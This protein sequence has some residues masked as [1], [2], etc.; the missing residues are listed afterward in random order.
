MLSILIPAYNY[1]IFPLVMQL[2]RQCI[3]AGIDFEIITLDDSSHSKLNSENKK[4]NNL[5]HCSFAEL[6]HNIGRS[7]IRNL[8]AQKAKYNWLLF[9]D[10]D[11]MP[12]NENFIKNYIKIMADEEKVISGGIR[13]QAT[14]PDNDKLL[15]WIYGNKREAL[16]VEERRQLPYT[17]LLTLN[18]LIA[19]SVFHKVRFNENIPNLRHEDTLFSHNLEEASIKAEHIKNRVIH[20]GLES[21]EIFLHK[22]EES[23]IGLKFLID[24]KL[25]TAEYTRIGKVYI[26]LQNMGVAG[27]VAFLF[28]LLQKTLRK[29][30]IGNR[31]S[32]FIFDIYRLGYLCT[33]R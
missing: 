17:R 23:L 19:K 20:H 9:L 1:N 18:F 6:A 16:T 2:H 31:P 8:L 13:Y 12:E 14:R 7:A 26:R 11:T 29:N 24:N 15:R 10:A 32:L 5:S 21:S 28:K 27:I 3:A 25:I 33:I 22:S 4:I 30:L